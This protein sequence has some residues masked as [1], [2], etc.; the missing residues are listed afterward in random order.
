L[1][2][3][4]LIVIEIA[5]AHGPSRYFAVW[6]LAWLLD[7]TYYLVLLPL[8]CPPLW[9]AML[10]N[11]SQSGK[12]H[13]L[14]TPGAIKKKIARFKA[15]VGSRT[16]ILDLIKVFKKI[17]FD[18]KIFKIYGLMKI[19]LIH[20]FIRK[21]Q[22]IWFDRNIQIIQNIQNIQNIPNIQHVER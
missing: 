15:D 6:M 10:V 21:L 22:N 13:S 20:D 3:N 8:S 2:R 1:D 9:T 7:L 17:Q 18:K 14:S 12:A 5:R 11:T 19:F 4:C 16:K